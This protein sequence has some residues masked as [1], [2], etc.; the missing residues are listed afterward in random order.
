MAQLYG[1][2]IRK[3]KFSSLKKSNTELLAFMASKPMHR[4]D[5]CYKQL[6]KEFD[7]PT[8]ES[9]FKVSDCISLFKIMNNTTKCVELKEYFLD[10][11]VNYPES[12]EKTPFY[13]LLMQR[14]YVKNEPVSR[15][16]ELGN[17]IIIKNPVSKN[18]DINVNIATSII[19][20]YYIKY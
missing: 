19:K 9:L 6:G 1:D 13:L 12:K 3:I 8:I 7:L 16:S 18:F 2:Y 20:K 14:N 4:F 15:M 10:K 17:K 11:Q 5:H